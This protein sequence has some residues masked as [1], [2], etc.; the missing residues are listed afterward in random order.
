MTARRYYS[1]TVM[2]APVGR[3]EP[4]FFRV[5][6]QRRLRGVT[7]AKAKAYARSVAWTFRKSHPSAT[8]EYGAA[9]VFILAFYPIPKRT[10]ARQRERMLQGKVRPEVKPDGSNVLKLVEDALEGLAYHNDSQVVVEH[11]EKWY[12][13]EPRIAVVVRIYDED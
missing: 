10:S 3:R 7:P 4:N 2:G 12:S 1:F 11:V 13:D 5:P 8:P 9:S 6:G